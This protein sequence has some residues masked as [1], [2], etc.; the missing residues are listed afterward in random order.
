MLVGGSRYVIRV[1]DCFCTW[2]FVFR[3][4]FVRSVISSFNQLL[5]YTWLH[6]LDMCDC[7][8]AVLLFDYAY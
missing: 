6:I 8:M 5:F 3:F 2:T 7:V 4:F 1:I